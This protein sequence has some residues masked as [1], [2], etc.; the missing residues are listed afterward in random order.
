MF[1]S[2]YNFCLRMG[3][4]FIASFKALSEV[5]EWVHEFENCILGPYLRCRP[6][7]ECFTH[8]LSDEDYAVFPA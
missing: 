1:L 2:D 8:L 5:K 3:S 7:S 6:I 4:I